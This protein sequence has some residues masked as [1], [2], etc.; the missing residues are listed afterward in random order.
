MYLFRRFTSLYTN[1]YP[2]DE[3]KKAIH[4]IKPFTVTHYFQLR[5]WR[6]NFSSINEL[7]EDI[8]VETRRLL[9]RP[10]RRNIRWIVIYDI[11][12]VISYFIWVVSCSVIARQFT[13]T[14]RL[15]RHS[16]LPFM[17]HWCTTLSPSLI[18]CSAIWPCTMHIHPNYS[19]VRTLRNFWNAATFGS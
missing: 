3:A 6:A 9:L 13:Q 15:S 18:P 4:W 2:S 10:M 11:L 16:F 8:D 19:W 14:H 12:R 7:T 5:Y 17:I 1:V